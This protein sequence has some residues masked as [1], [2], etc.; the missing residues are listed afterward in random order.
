MREKE[1]IKYSINKTEN[2]LAGWAG[3]SCHLILLNR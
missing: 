1:H 2:E 3:K